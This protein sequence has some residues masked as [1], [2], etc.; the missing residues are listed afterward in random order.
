MKVYWIRRQ[1]MT[2]ITR[3]GYVG[4][5]SLSLS[6]RFDQHSKNVYRK[7]IVKKAIDKYCDIVIDLVYEGCDEECL[8]FEATYR[9]EENIGWNIAKG[10]NIPTKMNVEKAAKISKTLK[11]KN[12]NPYSANTHS[13]TAIAKRKASMAGRKW[14]YN[15]TTFENRRLLEQPLGWIPGKIHT[16]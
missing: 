2:D 15:P 5:T 3:D 4:V 12:I 7:S 9:P 6:E 11:E 1:G 14:F 13:P 8:R 10:G 16:T